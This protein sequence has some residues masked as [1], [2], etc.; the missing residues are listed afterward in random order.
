MPHCCAHQVADCG[1]VCRVVAVDLPK[2][3]VGVQRLTQRSD[4]KI[5]RAQAFK[6]P[7]ADHRS[8]ALRVAEDDRRAYRKRLQRTAR[9]CEHQVVVRQDF[10]RLASCTPGASAQNVEFDVRA[11]ARLTHCRQVRLFTCV[12]TKDQR[13]PWSWCQWRL[14][15]FETIEIH[16]VEQYADLFFRNAE[17]TQTI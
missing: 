1:R 14:A 10:L 13:A 17:K 4:P 6:L 16:E 3:G 12:I 5:E 15:W 2:N 11:P 8:H 7:R 9:F